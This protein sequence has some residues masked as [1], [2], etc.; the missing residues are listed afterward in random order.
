DHRFGAWLFT[1]ARNRCLSELR[2]RKVPL[3][4]EAVLE[5]LADER[6]R[7]DEALEGRL[8]ERE[9]LDLVRTTLSPL[10]QDAL[11]LRCFEGMAVEAITR[12]LEIQESTGARAVLQRARRRL[13]AAL[14]ARDEGMRDEGTRGGSP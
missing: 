6:P 1:I 4:G 14:A 12:R 10:E 5:L 3:A 13:R 2:K 9:L 8:G 7:P 11:R